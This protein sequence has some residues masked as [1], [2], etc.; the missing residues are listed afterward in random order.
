MD[1][2]SEAAG[3]WPLGPGRG[4]TARHPPGDPLRERLEAACRERLGLTPW[5]SQWRAAQAML[6]GR[7]ADT[8]PGEGRTLALALAAATLALQGRR[9]HLLTA[10][11]PLAARDAAALAPWYA[12]LGLAVASFG[13]DT[14][15]QARRRAHQADVVYASGREMALDLLRDRLAGHGPTVR[16]ALDDHARALAGTPAGA[17]ADARRVPAPDVALL[18]DAGVLLLDE[19]MDPLV[20]ARPGE[21]G[22]L[23]RQLGTALDLAARL[24]PGVDA[25]LQPLARDARLTEA[26]ESRLSAL[27]EGLPRLWQHRMHRD[28][29]VRLALVATHLVQPGRDYRVRQGQ[30]L[31]IDRAGPGSGPGRGWPP[32]LHGMVCVREGLTPPPPADVLAHTTWTTFLAGYARVGGA[33]AGLRAERRELARLHGLAVERIAPA[34]PAGRQRLP[35]RWFPDAAARDEALAAHAIR[36]ASAGQPVLVGTDDVAATL[37]L[38]DAFARADPPAPAGLVALDGRQDAR[39]AA[40]LAQAGQ[41][42][43]ITV[44]TRATVRGVDI[45]PDGQARAAGGLLVLDARDR[46]PA[47][48]EVERFAALAGRRGEPGSAGRWRIAPGPWCGAGHAA[49]GLGWLPALRLAL[50]ERRQAGR[51]ADRRLR[52]VVGE[53]L[54]G[55]G[56]ALAMTALALALNGAMPATAPAATPEPPAAAPMPLGCLILPSRVADLGTPVPGV[57]ERVRVER[58]DRVRQGQPLVDLRA[59]GERAALEAAQ[60]RAGSAAAVGGA[61]AQHELARQKLA[62][63]E[64]LHA[65]RFISDL[66]LAQTRAEAEL[67]RQQWQQAEDQQRLH[68]AE[69]R[70]A[71][72]ALGQRTLRA[73]FDGVVL[74]RMTHP[75][76]RAELQPLLR[77]ADV[78]VLHVEV[79]APASMWGQVRVGAVRTVRPDLPGVPARAATVARVDE[80][81]DAASHTF[82]VRLALPNADRAVPAG[83]R[84]RIDL[85]E[86]PPAGAAR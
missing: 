84:C 37:R 15:P 1:L 17:Q 40:A 69:A 14:A 42:G 43:R 9:V 46:G 19:A 2:T 73:P 61:Q 7:L 44:V 54:L 8:A 32:G 82:R 83:A 47:R 74:D 70:Q 78:A 64:S 57:V 58:G 10:S 29:L 85:G 36:R 48:R 72:A 30:V 35:D 67:A 38:L 41:A 21:A 55:G 39:E 63:A 13:A 76:E 86:A 25:E 27:C 28:A 77:L 52:L 75:G 66:A 51:D 49:R 65:E 22:D 50:R 4:R 56:A 79:V 24:R 26:G 60:L 12:A 20:L 16:A 59:D 68:R 23:H 62:R 53:R 34:H 6:A 80:A 18:D 3:G 45:V 11:D 5:P 81:L 31:P 71:Q 33:G